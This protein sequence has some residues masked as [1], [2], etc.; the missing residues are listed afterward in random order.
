MGGT[1]STNGK[2]NV[3]KI[4]FGKPEGRDHFGSLDVDG[5]IILKSNLTED[6]FED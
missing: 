3:Y 1:S 4:L 6:K 5:S 2:I